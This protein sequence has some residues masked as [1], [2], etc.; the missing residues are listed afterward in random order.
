[1]NHTIPESIGAFVIVINPENQVLLGKRLNCYQAGTYGCPGGRL[2]LTETLES[3]ARRELFEETRLQAVS[4]HY[5][6]V[7]R[8]FQ[9][10]H[11]FVHFA[12]LCDH[13]EGDVILQEPDKCE[14]WNFYNFNQLPSPILPAH[15]HAIAHLQNQRPLDLIELL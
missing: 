5:V 6:G 1:M 11:N 14:S 13:F 4:L 10:D 3:A 9:Q 15:Q 8:E 12:Y 7:I 2:E